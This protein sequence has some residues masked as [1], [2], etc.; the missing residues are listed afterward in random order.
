MEGSRLTQE[1]TRYIFDTNTIGLDSKIYHI[2]DIVETVN[3]FR[4]IDDIIY[5]ANKPLTEKYIKHIH[6]IL[7]T[8]TSDAK[9]D[10]F[11]V[12]DYKKTSK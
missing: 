7:K 9:N 12:K 5:N 3:H 6:Q 2:D 10:W 1:E 11:A 4:A 8:G